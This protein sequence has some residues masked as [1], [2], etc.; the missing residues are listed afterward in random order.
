MFEFVSLW[1]DF[2]RL[3]LRIYKRASAETLV[4]YSSVRHS[5]QKVCKARIKNLIRAPFVN[6]CMIIKA[7]RKGS[8]S[9]RDNTVHKIHLLYTN[10]WENRA[11]D[12]G[13]KTSMVM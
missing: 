5:A 11:F 10:Y 2:S 7:R 13:G 12:R 8:F 1:A 6:I 9:V 3:N 4:G